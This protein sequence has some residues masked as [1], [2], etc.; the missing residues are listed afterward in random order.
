M[1]EMRVSGDEESRKLGL[2]AEGK[3]GALRSVHTPR[4]MERVCC[5]RINDFDGGV[6]FGKGRSLICKMGA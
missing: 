1:G 5:R 2:E 4:S 6:L 3:Q